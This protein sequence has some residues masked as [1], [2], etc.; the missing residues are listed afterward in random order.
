MNQ[1]KAI[2]YVRASTN[3]DLQQNSISIQQD[4]LNEFA[5]QHN[6]EIT[7]FYVEYSSGGDDERPVMN[8][9]LNY[10]I[11]NNCVLISWKVD[12]F[13]R[14]LSIFSRIQEHLSLLRFTEL[15]DTEPNVMVLS[16]LLGVAYQ[17]RKNTSIRVKASYKYLKEKNPNLAWG[18][19][20]MATEVQ[21]LGE[22]TRIRNATEFNAA[23]QGIVKDLRSAGYSSIKALAERL[24]A[25][26]ITTR[27]GKPFTTNN[28]QRVLAYKGA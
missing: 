9:A 26:G 23:I 16:V 3:P 19:P 17:E 18:N 2:G 6:Y 12:R 5:K 7:S 14:S 22:K 27:R 4:L 10:A 21:P 8:E 1:R 28:L 25:M 20:A 11:S 13:A 24:N 15:G